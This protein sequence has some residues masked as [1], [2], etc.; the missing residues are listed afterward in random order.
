VNGLSSN[1]FSDATAAW[2]KHR[3]VDNYNKFIK[4]HQW[5]RN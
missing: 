1:V 3:L 4:S 5:Q 2:D